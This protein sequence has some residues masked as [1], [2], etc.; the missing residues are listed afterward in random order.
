M[1]FDQNSFTVSDIVPQNADSLSMNDEDFSGPVEAA[2]KPTESS[3]EEPLM[4]DS[5]SS[6]FEEESSSF[7]CSYS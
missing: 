6:S 4:I 7:E 2:S 3:D 5:S 1:V